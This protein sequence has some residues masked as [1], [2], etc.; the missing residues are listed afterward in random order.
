MRLEMNAPYLKVIC[1]IGIVYAS[2]DR[3]P[4]APVTAPMSGLSRVLLQKVGS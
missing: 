2:A 1:V 4:A 3:L